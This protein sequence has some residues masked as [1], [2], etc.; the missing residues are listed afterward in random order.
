[1]LAILTYFSIKYSAARETCHAISHWQN[2]ILSICG[3]W[4][5]GSCNHPKFAIIKLSKN[6]QII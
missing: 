3:N 6:L 1:L 5:D 2:E 4:L